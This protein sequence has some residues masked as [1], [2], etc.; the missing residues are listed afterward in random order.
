MSA[1][2]GDEGS[3]LEEQARMESLAILSAAIAG[4]ARQALP[5]PIEPIDCVDC[6]VV[7]PLERLRLNPRTRRC[8]PCAHDIE[9]SRG[10]R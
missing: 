3:R 8:T 1:D 9:R 2:F 7:V 10:P 5:V 6:G 4:N